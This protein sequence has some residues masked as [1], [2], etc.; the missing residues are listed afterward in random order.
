MM[1][2]VPTKDVATPAATLATQV[3]RPTDS[4]SQTGNW[5][6][7]V[8]SSGSCPRPAPPAVGVPWPTRAS[9]VGRY[10]HSGVRAGVSCGGAHHAWRLQTA[11]PVV[12]PDDEELDAPVNDLFNRPQVDVDL[13]E[14]IEL[15]TRLMVAASQVDGALSIVQVD[16]VLGVDDGFASDQ[17]PVGPVQSRKPGPGFD[18][19][20][21]A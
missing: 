5:T 20:S 9:R 18:R 16:A 11:R 13:L 17:W 19:G 4:T 7:P 15:L 3:T 1:N 6:S 8:P 14:E 12:G 10:G 2:A 21:P